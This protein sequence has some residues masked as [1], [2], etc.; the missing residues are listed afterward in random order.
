MTKQTTIKIGGACGYWGES[1]LSTPQLLKVDGLNY[2]VYDYLAEITMSIMA[3]ARAS[4]PEKGYAAD[5][6]SAV[7]KPN[8]KIIADKGVK[9]LSNAGGVNPEACGN[10][11]RKLVKEL[12]LD[13]KV[14]VIIGDDLMPQINQITET[15]PLEMFA[16]NAFPAQEKIASMNAYLGAKPI[17]T[18][19]QNGADIV[20]TGRCADSALTLAAC[21]HEFGWSN[22]EYDHLA[23]GS[24]AGHLLECGPQATGGNFTDWHLVKDTI[25]NIGY[26]VADIHQ[27]GSM[28]ISKPDGTGGTVS[29]GTVSEQLI[30]EIEDPQ[31]YLLPDVSCDFSK[32]IIEQTN[33]DQVSVS[34]AKGRAP[35]GKYKVSTT[36]MDG[37]K[38]G[39]LMTFVGFDAAKKAQTLGNA[40][41]KR[42][43]HILRLSNAGE[44]TEKSIELIGDDSQF[45]GTNTH[46][47]EVTLKLA[48]K[49]P[50]AEAVGLLL[51]E[52]AGIGL[53][54]PAG[55]TAFN[56]GR[57]KPSPVIRLFSFLID[58][59]ELAIKCQLDD[60][61]ISI[62]DPIKAA[63]SMDII[64]PNTPDTSNIANGEDM[65]EIPLI[66][67]AWARSGDKGN[68]A[69]IGIIAR[70]AE[71]IP[72]IWKT[73]DEAAVKNHFKHFE[74]T[75][76]DRFFMPGMNAI[77]FVLHD[78][79]GGGGI[80]SLRADPQG[81]AYGQIL[82]HH[83]IPVPREL[84]D[85]LQKES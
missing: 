26:P 29:V 12:D 20:I 62:S 10:M 48:A 3:R 2:I 79:L 9:I 15:A 73:L 57:P 38:C 40:V 63:P 34:G 30:Y 8:L 67:L 56:A 85:I 44:Y 22:D 7:L 16:G 81:K 54:T 23:A 28:V 4:D 17:V 78:T 21:Q 5:F 32:V 51:K 83:M 43:E 82:L 1:A 14:A 37:F 33:Q 46:S 61:T 53:A 68:R 24:L 71:Y 31:N 35:S 84:A 58:S 18:A 75:S 6:V 11:V 74:A 77:N 25:H 52:M 50:K 45:G 19:L 13:L 70:K 60:Q 47:K 66:D 55:L 49:H 65:V 64:R 69:N 36:Y 80:A 41:F 59:D 27:D 72:F 76:V 42:A 39:A